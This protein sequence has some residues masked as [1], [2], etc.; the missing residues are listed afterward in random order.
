MPW[1]DAEIRRNRDY[2]AEKIG[3]MKERNKV[4]SAVESGTMDFVLLDVRGRDP[5]A[6][7]HIPGAWCAPITELDAV[8]SQLPKDREIVTYCWGH[9]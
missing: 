5:F 8:L 4:L 7:G 1:T 3:A 9:D 6:M 2:F